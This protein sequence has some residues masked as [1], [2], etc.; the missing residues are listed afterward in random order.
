M[1]TMGEESIEGENERMKDVDGTK[2]VNDI[3]RKEGGEIHT[4]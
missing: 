4:W 1:K 2:L 3:I